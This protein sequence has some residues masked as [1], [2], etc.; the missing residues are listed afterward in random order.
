[1][2]NYKKDKHK[3]F[4]SNGRVLTTS[5]FEELSDPR[6]GGKY[7]LFKLEDWHEQYVA[8]SDPTEYKTALALIGNYE[9]WVKMLEHPSFFKHI[10]QWRKEVDVKLEA[11]GIQNLREQARLGNAT[12]ARFLAKKEYKEK[13]AKY[14]KKEKE[15]TEAQQLGEDAAR[16]GLKLVSGGK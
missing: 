11:E 12:A 7:V 2:F 16:I 15:D 6:N 10:E 13:L 14:E 3:L 1:M 4:D 5:L 9:H 8:I